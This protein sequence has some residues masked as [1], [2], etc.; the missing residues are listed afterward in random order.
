[1]LLSASLCLIKLGCAFSVSFPGSFRKCVWECVTGSRRLKPYKVCL[2]QFSAPWDTSLFNSLTS[3][4]RISVTAVRSE[5]FYV[6]VQFQ[7]VFNLLKMYDKKWFGMICS[8]RYCLD[9][10]E[11]P[12]CNKLLSIRYYMYI[13]LF[14]SKRCL[15]LSSFLHCEKPSHPASLW[16]RQD[17]MK[18]LNRWFTYAD[19]HNHA[20]ETLIN[21][22]W[23]SYSRN[24]NVEYFKFDCNILY[25]EWLVRHG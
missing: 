25:G 20:K 17:S 24:R 15:L 7:S 19:C 1:M 2:V 21:Y 3:K 5:T 14:S 18:L 12:K 13:C 9:I 4:H 16:D 23:Y 10:S 6:F 22:C 11:L 8:K